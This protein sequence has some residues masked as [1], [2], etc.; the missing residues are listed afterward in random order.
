MLNNKLKLFIWDI[1]VNSLAEFKLETLENENSINLLLL[2][3]WLSDKDRVLVELIQKGGTFMVRAI[4]LEG[5]IDNQILRFKTKIKAH[6]T[7]IVEIRGRFEYLKTIKEKLPKI[8]DILLDLRIKDA[9]GNYFDY[10]NKNTNQILM[11]EE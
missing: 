7:K 6:I 10:L 4:P 9:F 1:Y 11:C 2:Y 3:R 5:K 8:R